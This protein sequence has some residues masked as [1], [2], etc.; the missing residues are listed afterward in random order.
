MPFYALLERVDGRRG[1]NRSIELPGFI[2]QD[3]SEG[4]WATPPLY[5]LWD[6]ASGP[7]CSWKIDAEPGHFTST[8]TYAQRR[9]G[10]I[11]GLG[12]WRTSRGARATT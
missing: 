3:P 12:W 4:A 1:E 8:A 7:S 9:L 2:C 10:V 6:W 11:L 5:L